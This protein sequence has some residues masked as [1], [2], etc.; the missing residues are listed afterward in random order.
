MKNQLKATL[1]NGVEMP[2]LGFGTFKVPDGETAVQSVKTAL[3][4]GYRHIDTAAI[5]GNE[6]GVGEGIR[7][8]G[9]DRKDIFL[10]SK[11]WNSDQGY[12]STLRA[13][14][15]SMQR[16]GFD[17]LDLY[18]IH[19]PKPLNRE[20]WR[21]MEKL[22]K[23]KRIRAIGVS[24]F[25][26]HHLEDLFTS[27]EIK[28]AVNQIEFHPRLVQQPLLDFCK[29]HRIQF[30]AW[31]PLMQG[32]IFD[33]PLLKELSVKYRRSISQIVL[34]WD[35][36]M[37]VVTIPKST[38]SERIKENMGIFDFEI[39]EKDMNDITAL[40]KGQRVG[41]DPDNFNF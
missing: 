37:G 19:W 21:A 27:C 22:Y 7:Q 25:H 10:T 34:R 20:T 23:E 39:I 24:N 13:F 11:L 30:E 17:Y 1:N 9:I 26:V 31:S 41:A 2:M 16:L 6:C 12:D 5:Y 33:I 8:S 18:L 29:K 36:Q 38:N 3:S 15:A 40:D 32:K 35:V 14:D 4:L 28:P